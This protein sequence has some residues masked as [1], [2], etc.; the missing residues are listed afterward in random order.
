M[1]QTCNSYG[2]INHL[3][4]LIS[5]MTTNIVWC[6]VYLAFDHVH[7]PVIAKVHSP[8]TLECSQLHQLLNLRQFIMEKL[9]IFKK[10]FVSYRVYVNFSYRINCFN[11]SPPSIL[12]LYSINDTQSSSKLLWHCM[13]MWSTQSKY[14]STSLP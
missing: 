6:T 5:Y 14:D 4:Y 13:V 10:S 3:I 1:K 2:M 7:V 8:K 9:N 12:L 11:P